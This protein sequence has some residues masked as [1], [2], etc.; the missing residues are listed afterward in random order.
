MN[1]CENNS[2]NR[3]KNWKFRIF[4]QSEIYN[5]Q[6]NGDNSLLELQNAMF[7]AYENAWINSD[8]GAST[9]SMNKLRTYKLFKGTYEVEAYVKTVMPR[10]H[11][12]ALAK[13]RCGVAPD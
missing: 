1:G 3:Y 10:C 6:E 2:S 11:R 8:C 7:N 12:S 9:S 4:K 5:I 13:F